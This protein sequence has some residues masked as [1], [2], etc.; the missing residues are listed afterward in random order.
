MTV[1]TFDDVTKRFKGV[2]LLAGVSLR[3]EKGVTYGLTGPNGSGK[4]VAMLMMCGLMSPTVGSVRIDPAYLAKGRSF[5]DRFGVAINGPSFVGGL[6]ALDNLK[7]LARIRRRASAADCE[8]MLDAVGL[9]PHSQLPARK[10]SLGM[11]QKLSL[12]QAFIE[13]PEVLLLDEPF[14]ALDERSVGVV[15][16]LL[17]D[18]Q[19]QGCTIVLTSHNAADIDEFS[20]RVLKVVDRRI[21]EVR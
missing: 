15:G 6:S 7:D 1:L 16:E 10:F 14:N 20:E 13:E 21:E 19:R 9:D 11:K 18:F 2:E 5:P 12:A 3:I 8:A 4:S 17:R